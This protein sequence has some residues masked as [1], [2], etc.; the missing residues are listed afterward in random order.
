M[1]NVFEHVFEEINPG[2]RRCQVCGIHTEG[3]HS[4]L[5][6]SFRP[7]E[8]FN[9]ETDRM[10]VITFEMG[11]VKFRQTIQ[12][13]WYPLIAPDLTM[14]CGL[15]AE[16]EWMAAVRDRVTQ[17]PS[18]LIRFGICGLYSL[19]TE[20]AKKAPAP[21]FMGGGPSVAYVGMRECPKHGF[22]RHSIGDSRTLCLLCSGVSKDAENAA[23]S[24]RADYPIALTLP[25]D[26]VAESSRLI[27]IEEAKKLRDSLDRVIRQVE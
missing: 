4:E 9:P 1:V 24:G 16:A 13:P 10:L 5:F 25:G 2:I 12:I 23:Q 3:P 21:N 14:C 17:P 11:T 7:C 15:D 18:D 19:W 8:A 22:T 26:S 27:S 6:A 20:Q